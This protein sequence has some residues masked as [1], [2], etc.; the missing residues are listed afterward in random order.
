MVDFASPPWP[1]VVGSL[2]VGLLLV[3]FFANLFG[4]LDAR[5]ALYPAMNLVGGGLSCWASW[6]IDYLPFVVLEG[7]WALV[8]AAALLRPAVRGARR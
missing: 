6:L 7:T 8:A 1:T 3:A 4:R 5:R 2:G